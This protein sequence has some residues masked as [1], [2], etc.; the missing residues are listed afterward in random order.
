LDHFQLRDLWGHYGITPK[1]G[2]QDSRVESMEKVMFLDQ[3]GQDARQKI[4]RHRAQGRIGVGRNQIGD[5]QATAT[6]CHEAGKKTQ[7]AG[8]HCLYCWQET[9]MSLRCR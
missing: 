3:A 9:R 1:K 7:M 6:P 4:L 8:S 2:G 5:E